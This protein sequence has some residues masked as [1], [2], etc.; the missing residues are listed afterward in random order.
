MRTTLKEYPQIIVEFTCNCAQHASS[1][2]KREQS[3][4]RAPSDNFSDVE[5]LVDVF[6]HLAARLLDVLDESFVMLGPVVNLGGAEEG[7]PHPVLVV[8][9]VRLAPHPHVELLERR[10]LEVFA[11]LFGVLQG[12]GAQLLRAD[13]HD[14]FSLFLK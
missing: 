2:N 8:V 1:A 12:Q 9:V 13:A 3:C 11:V 5:R 10:S 4:T 14:L 6:R 7:V